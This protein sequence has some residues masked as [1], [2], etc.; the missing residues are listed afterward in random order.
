MM[1]GGHSDPGPPRVTE[2]PA[3]EL[4]LFEWGAPD[5]L[6]VA[7][8]FVGVR[9]A[10]ADA[11]VLVVRG[12]EAV[13]RLPALSDGL[14]RPPE[15]GKRW[16]ATFVWQT[17]PVPFDGAQLELGADIVVELPQPG[18]KGFEPPRVLE[19]RRTPES[20]GPA[21]PAE[22]APRSDVPEG[23]VGRVHLQAELLAAQQ[24]VREL[25]TSLQQAQEELSRA[26]EDL[27]AERE[28]RAADA[29]R[30]RDGLAQVEA[31]AEEALAAEKAASQQLG[32]DLREAHQAM[33]AREAA[34]TELRGQL[35]A[36]AAER[37]R[38][39]S[40]ARAEVDALRERLASLE[41]AAE[42]MDQLRSDLARTREQADGARA[43]LEK[44][45]S[46][47]EEARTDAQRLLGRLTSIGDARDAQG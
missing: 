20:H 34:L 10:P 11:P 44:T 15:D 33:Q 2:R 18:P 9:E 19:V 45:R 12:A 32:S 17:A 22:P 42:E 5:R 21:A 16:T 26:Q 23:G 14:S 31:S 47:M 46:A 13:H 35:E 43:K 29:A 41:P 6:D 40:E 7:G 27:G 30:F 36:A 37:R 24:E 4:E 25:R 38:A 1:G 3:F 8:R 28:R 39:V